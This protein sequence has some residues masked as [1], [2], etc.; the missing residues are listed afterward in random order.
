M[1]QRF[2]WFPLIDSELLNELLLIV[3]TSINNQ[4]NPKGQSKEQLLVVKQQ[5]ELI[6]KQL[7]SAL[8]QSYFVIPIGTSQVSIPLTSGQYTNSGYSY[9]IVKRVYDEL[10]SLGWIDIDKGVEVK[11]RVT[12]ISA[13]DPLVSQFAE[14]GLQWLRQEP[15]APELLVQLRHYKNPEGKT[16]KAKGK[17]IE[18]PLPDTDEVNQLRSSLYAYN[19]FLIQQCVALDLNDDQLND[20]G[21]AM[22]KKANDEPWKNEEDDQYVSTL[23]FYRL[24]L[25]RIFSRGSMELGGRFYGGW[26]QSIP[27]LYRPHI[28]INGYKTVE[29]DYSSMSL[30]ILY[31]QRGIDVP[32][33]EDLYDIGLDDWL[34][35]DDPRRKPIKTYINAVLNDETG[36]YRLA[37]DKQELVGISHYQ[38]HDLVLKRHQ[39]IA[40][41]LSSGIG[42]QTQYIDSQIAELVM[43]RMMEESV[44]VLPIH[45]SFIVRKGYQANLADCMH[46]AFTKLTG[47]IGSVDIEGSRSSQHFGMQKESLAE[48]NK[49]PS[50]GIYT[51]AEAFEE[52][53]SKRSSV[54]KRYIESWK[55]IACDH[56]N[57]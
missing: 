4:R 22:Q 35:G 56:L 45:D 23:D 13:K 3:T 10:S 1:D 24:Q 21:K 55:L 54:M 16:K 31:S 26:W 47:A 17:K 12:R 42:L 37:K 27:S 32:P 5:E 14:F 46:K 6:I 2:D 57:E 52:L 29:I 11:G 44:L 18:L 41:L 33:N 8:Y 39:G 28:T 19:Q 9:R 49:D 36:N 43:Q 7:L 34:G 15:K 50:Y 48:L 30:R 40:D 20:V 38:L 51:F 53:L 25:R